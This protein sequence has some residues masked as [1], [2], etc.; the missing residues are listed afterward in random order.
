MRENYR[1]EELL[2][3][4]APF[5]SGYHTLLGWDAFS[6]LLPAGSNPP[7]PGM[8]PRKA[9]SVRL[10]PMAMESPQLP[11]NAWMSSRSLFSSPNWTLD[12]FGFGGSP[13]S[14]PP[15]LMQMH[16]GAAPTPMATLETQTT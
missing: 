10:F 3:H 9:R 15:S 16:A 1:S 11:W 13:H 2:F 4:V 6:P 5:N 8:Q 7:R 14:H 12:C